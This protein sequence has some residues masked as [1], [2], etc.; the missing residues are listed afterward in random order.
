[1]PGPAAPLAFAGA[2]V[3]RILPVTITAGNVGVAFAALSYA[4]RLAVSVIVDPDVV[5]EADAVAEALAGELRAVAD[6]EGPELGLTPRAGHHRPT[7]G[8]PR[9][10]AG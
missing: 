10:P 5:P 4:G 9:R 1:M 3:L 6:A 8:S 7:R 2:P